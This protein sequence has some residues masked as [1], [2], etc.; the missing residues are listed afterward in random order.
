M[1]VLLRRNI[2]TFCNKHQ[3]YRK[4][5]AMKNA[6]SFDVV[7]SQDLMMLPEIY[8]S[9]KNSPCLKLTG[10]TIA[11]KARCL[12]T[13]SVEFSHPNFMDFCGHN[14]LT[15]LYSFLYVFLHKI[16][17]ITGVILFVSF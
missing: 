17:L 11:F 1:A 10:I 12:I 7:C 14:L 9:F 5:C 3:I 6:C 13:S 16:C 4:S 15:K 8:M 2:G